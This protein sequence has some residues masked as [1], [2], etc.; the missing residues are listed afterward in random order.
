MMDTIISIITFDQVSS[1]TALYWRGTYLAVKSLYRGKHLRSVLQLWVISCLHGNIC[2][3]DAFLVVEKIHRKGA[4]KY[5]ISIMT[6][7]GRERECWFSFQFVKKLNHSV[8]YVPCRPIQPCRQSNLLIWC[9][10]SIK[11]YKDLGFVPRIQDARKPNV[12]P[13]QI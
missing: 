4:S 8:W 12:L 2:F 13:V 9:W 10:L 3:L 5:H 1:D 11:K 6:A 7:Y